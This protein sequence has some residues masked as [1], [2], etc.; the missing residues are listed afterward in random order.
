MTRTRILFAVSMLV[1][2][3]AVTAAC[4]G[5]S[6]HDDDMMS[7]DGGMMSGPQPEGSIKVGLVNWAM[8]PER[9]STKAGT[10][11]FWA[12]HDMAHMHGASEGG[13]THDLQVMKKGADGSMELVGQVQGLT[14]GQ[15]RELT[16]DLT[17]GEYE[18][19]CNVVEE[20]NGKS[21]G[22]Y[23]K[24]MHTPFRVTADR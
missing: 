23:V 12:V 17:P 22:H 15:A 14:M 19:S 21:V 3:A 8:E 5:D 18:L 9:S 13:V 4:G 11:T 24:G 10:V 1:A 2:A 7:A 6:H 16:L 20:I